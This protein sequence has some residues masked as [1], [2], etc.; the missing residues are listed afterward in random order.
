MRIP[1]C[2]GEEGRGVCCWGS[3]NTTLLCSARGVWGA[4]FTVWV[5]SRRTLSQNSLQHPLHSTCDGAPAPLCPQ[6]WSSLIPVLHPCEP[7]FP[8]PGRECLL[9]STGHLG[10]GLTVPYVDQ[11]C[12]HFSAHRLP[13]QVPR[14]LES[15]D[16]FALR[17]CSKVLSDGGLLSFDRGVVTPLSTFWLPKIHLNFTSPSIMIVLV[18]LFL[19][20][21]LFSK[22]PT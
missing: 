14:S 16:F 13:C 8:W 12:S 2:L 10:R 22:L 6:S 17:F 19:L 3:I 11:N 4:A 5:F 20:H 18:R 15:P 21:I 1:P 9:A 7:P